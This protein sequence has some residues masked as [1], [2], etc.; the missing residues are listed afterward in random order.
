MTASSSSA[1]TSGIQKIAYGMK[2]NIFRTEGIVADMIR[3][4]PN[5]FETNS[6]PMFNSLCN[7]VLL[8]PDQSD[9]RY[10]QAFL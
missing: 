2:Q 4:S 9:D 3:Q 8:L 7:L 10:R 1:D 6:Y 5:G